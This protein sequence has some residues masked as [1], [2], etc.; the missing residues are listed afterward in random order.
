MAS[1]LTN[2]IPAGSAASSRAKDLLVLGDDDEDLRDEERRAKVRLVSLN[3]LDPLNL[4]TLLI[5][6]VLIAPEAVT[7]SPGGRETVPRP[8]SPSGQ[9]QGAAPS[10]L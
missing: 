8:R 1:S 6:A 5:A 3:L 2:C 7:E 4:A 10:L 9:N